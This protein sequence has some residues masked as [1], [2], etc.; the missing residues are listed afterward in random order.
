MKR[1][2]FLA[3]LIVTLFV[4]NFSYAQMLGNDSDTTAS[5]ISEVNADY[6]LWL[7]M[8]R[9]NYHF[10]EIYEAALEL[11]KERFLDLNKIQI[12]D[13]VLFPPR[14]NNSSIEYWIADEPTL[15]D[16]KHDCI[17]RLTKRYIAYELPTKPVL[18]DPVIT[19]IIEPVVSD[20][21]TTI[22]WWSW[23]I[24]GF[25]ILLIIILFIYN[26]IRASNDPNNYVKVIGEGLDDDPKIAAQQISAIRK[27]P[28]NDLIKAE[29]VIL[30]R[31]YGVK[32][33]GVKMD[34]GDGISRLVK[35]KPG[36]EYVLVTLKHGKGSIEELYRSHCGN[37]TGPIISSGR[38]D[39][40]GR[41]KDGK[42][43]LPDGWHFIYEKS[44]EPAKEATNEIEKTAAPENSSQASSS[45]EPKTSTKQEPTVAL[46]LVKIIMESANKNAKTMIKIK[47]EEV[48]LTIIS[49]DEKSKQ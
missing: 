44:Y 3:I 33:L 8:N 17:W 2:M 11:N 21:K 48:K 46:E 22:S 7:K 18:K 31:N 15:H 47:G 28:L 25:I 32:T 20:S 37:K 34:F 26:Q 38:I 6:E 19:P 40:L 30:A 29:K 43:I 16:G 41:N 35:I 9:G 24:L 36:E 12:G 4:S 39:T 23:L 5:L 10:H 1:T 42:I 49:K 27:T 14:T 13:T 45:K